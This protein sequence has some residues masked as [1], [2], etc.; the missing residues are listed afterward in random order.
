MHLIPLPLPD[1]AP[2]SCHFLCIAFSLLLLFVVLSSFSA[3]FHPHGRFSPFVVIAVFVF[4]LLRRPRSSCF[5]STLLL[6]IDSPPPHRPSSSSLS[7][8]LLLIDPPAPRHC[9]PSSSLSTLLLGLARAGHSP[10]LASPPRDVLS[11]SLSPSPSLSLSSSPSS[12]FCCFRVLGCSG[13]IRWVNE[14]QEKT[15]HDICHGPFS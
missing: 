10:L 9:Q 13:F 5:S 7:T 14:G 2:L 4:P 6:L 1:L 12:L 15:G 11:L 8:L 3:S